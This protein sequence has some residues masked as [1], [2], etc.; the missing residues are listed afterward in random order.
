M[1]VIDINGN[2]CAKTTGGSVAWGTITGTLSS[3]TDLQTALNAKQNT[4]VSGTNIKT[5]NSTSLLGSGDIAI[6]TGLT[7]GTTAIAS[8]TIGRILFEGTGNV[9]Q[10]DAAFTFDNTLKRLQIIATTGGG[11]AD[12]PL[13]V[14]NSANTLDIVKFRANGNHVLSSEGGT[15]LNIL[16]KSGYSYPSLNLSGQGGTENAGIRQTSNRLTFINTTSNTAT[17]TITT[18]GLAIGFGDVG[19]SA[20]LD[21]K[22]QGALSTDIA[23]RVRNSANSA[24]IAT[25]QGDGAFTVGTYTNP[26]TKLSIS[27]SSIGVYSNATLTGVS[28]IVNP[29]TL[30]NSTG[31]DS[32]VRVSGAAPSGNYFGVNIGVDSGNVNTILYGLRA[33]SN[34]GGTNYGGYFRAYGGTSNHALY[35]QDGDMRFGA[36]TTNKIG[37]WNTTPILQPTTA[38]TSAAFVSNSGT[39]VHETS[40]F[41]GYTLQQIVKALRNTGLLA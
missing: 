6:S 34:G 20:K 15:S 32:F 13:L 3:Q 16:T 2:I 18:T 10:Q 24:N 41:D 21:V 7:V 17:A 33:T 35:V 1:Q 40:T 28:A 26:N 31:F 23:F 27:G 8:G 12:V 36:T 9:L 11:A 4:L 19:A 29:A 39:T 22:A 14:R 5:I 38:V 30:V 25:I 37:F